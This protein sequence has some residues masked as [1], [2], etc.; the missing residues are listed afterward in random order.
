MMNKILT[1]LINEKKVT[2]FVNDV[3]V[4]T[5]TE[6]R[7]DEIVKKVLR[8][9]KKNDLYVKPEKLTAECRKDVPEQREK[10]RLN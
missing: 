7:H 8:R 2:T 4:R 3:L 10:K 6:K 9:L 5:E 1:D